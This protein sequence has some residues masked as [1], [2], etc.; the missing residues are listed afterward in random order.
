[1]KYHNSLYIYHYFQSKSKQKQINKKQNKHLLQTRDVDKKK[2]EKNLE[3]KIK[4]ILK[5]I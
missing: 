3:I 4:Y 2:T 1:M 5:I